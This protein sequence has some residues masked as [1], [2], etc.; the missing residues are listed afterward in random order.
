MGVV[1]CTGLSC[2]L[3]ISSRSVL[4]LLFRILRSLPFQLGFPWSLPMML[5]FLRPCVILSPL[6]HPIFRLVP[7]LVRLRIL[8]RVTLC[9]L[10]C[11]RFRRVSVHSFLSLRSILPWLSASC[12][13]GYIRASVSSGPSVS[14]VH[15]F[16]T[17]SWSLS[18]RS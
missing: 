7:C 2:P 5:F 12:V 10:L 13:P 17:L 14:S 16:S 8:R 6:L 18:L 9:F 1:C 11:P 3:S 15:G 4:T